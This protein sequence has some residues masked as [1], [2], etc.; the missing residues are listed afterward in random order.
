M[1]QCIG[2]AVGAA[3]CL[4][5]CGPG[6]PVDVRGR[7]SADGP[8]P[9][10]VRASV[11]AEH[12]RDAPRYLR[13]AIAS[14]QTLTPWLGPFPHSSL[15][16][17]DPAWHA[18]PP[19]SGSDIV[20]PRTPWWSSPASMAPELA[21]ARAIARRYWLEVVDTR[22]LPDWFVDGVVEY[23][24]RRVVAPLFESAYLPPG[25]AMVE[26]RYFGGLVPRFLR[27]RLLPESDG[28]PLEAYRAR[29]RVDVTS[30]ASSDDRRSLSGKTLLTLNTLERWVSRP[31]FDGALA[32]FVRTSRGSQPT[33]NDFARAVSAAG[34]QD[35]SWF[36][37]QTL[38]GSAVFDYS[39]AELTSVAGVS[40]MFETTVVV[41]RLGDGLFTGTS[42]PRVGPF[43][44]G[45]GMTLLV[46][47]ADGERAVDRW[48]GR[49]A[50]KTFEYRSPSRA[51]SA[52][53]DPDRTLVLDVHLT[54]NSRMIAP[55][56]GAAATRWAALWMVWLENVL[57]T[58]S[59]L[60]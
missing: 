16:I 41:A 4:I 48:D 21:T 47:F 58:F 3:T 9:V 8:S 29:P 14:L 36:F 60:I 11:Q 28:G 20:L 51:V 25:Y 50:R 17:V 39:V 44:S 40:G 33:L 56:N 19:S 15:T 59:A 49:D 34:S 2:I 53:I 35:L 18:A 26:S 1:Y 10:E 46:T 30:P 43:E 38:G 32:E 37:V 13:A 24:A 27:L 45:R 5:G 54:N 7:F 55:R 31:V 23:L 6:S 42:A 52:T 12:R 57:L 22:A